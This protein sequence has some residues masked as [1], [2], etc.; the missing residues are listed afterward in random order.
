M[1]QRLHLLLE[2]LGQS[3]LGLWCKCAARLPHLLAMVQQSSLGLGCS[4]YLRDHSLCL[5]MGYR[6]CL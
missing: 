3:T 5:L 2:R 4:P 6:G 1:V